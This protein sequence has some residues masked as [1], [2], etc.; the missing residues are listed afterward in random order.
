MKTAMT[1]TPFPYA[2]EYDQSD[3]LLERARL[4][5]PPLP[6]IFGITPDQVTPPDLAVALQHARTSAV[7]ARIRTDPLALA[8]ALDT[9]A[10]YEF[11]DNAWSR[12]CWTW[13]QA[14]QLYR[15]LGDEAQANRTLVQAMICAWLRQDPKWQ[16]MHILV[17]TLDLQN[18]AFREYHVWQALRYWEKLACWQPL[19]PVTPL[20]QRPLDHHIT[21]LLAHSDPWTQTTGEWLS[22]LHGTAELDD[23]DFTLEEIAA[24]RLVTPIAPAAQALWLYLAGRCW[25]HLQQ[26]GWAWLLLE[27]ARGIHPGEPRNGGIPLAV[28]VSG[29]AEYAM[30]SLHLTP[31]EKEC[32][33]LRATENHSH[34]AFVRGV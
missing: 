5:P 13:E 28:W 22:T 32:L 34:A 14:C 8:N 30:L 26:P 15:Q 24:R 10:F 33:K 27:L 31:I 11:Q 20:D 1:M 2:T 21:C 16:A 7:H 9:L 12:A 19:S 25:I 17:Q 4:I 29:A 23:W 3:P 6:Q 18:D